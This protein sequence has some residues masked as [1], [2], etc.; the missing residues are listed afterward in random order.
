MCFLAVVLTLHPEQQAPPLTMADGVYAHAALFHALS[1]IDPEAGEALHAM[2]RHKHLTIAFIESRPR[3][4]KLRLT[5]LAEEGVTTANLLLNAF[6]IEPVLCLG[7]YR[8]HIASIDLSP[9]AWSGVQT[10]ADFVAESTSHCIKITFVTP[11]AFM[12]RDETGQRF[13]ALYPDPTTLFPGLIHR[14]Q[15]LAGPPLPEGLLAFLEAGRCLISSYKL[16]TEQFQ[17]AERSQIGFRGWVNYTC[18][19]QADQYLQAITALARLATFT[20]VGYQTARGMGAV[21]VNCAS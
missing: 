14:W 5:F 3:H 6:Q 10:W 1:N 12:K 21:R 15:A 2:R 11:T 17:T 4:S 18:A 20:G 9:T 16:H 7:K 8:W 13:T 19:T